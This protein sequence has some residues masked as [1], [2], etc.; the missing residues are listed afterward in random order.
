MIVLL[1]LTS[2]ESVVGEFVER[3]EQITRIR[4]PLNY[5]GMNPTML[6]YDPTYIS[7]LKYDYICDTEEVFFN[8]NAIVSMTNLCDVAVKLY[9][10]TVKIIYDDFL[11]I[12][13]SDFIETIEF[14]KR[15]NN[16]MREKINKQNDPNKAIIDSIPEN[17]HEL[18]NTK[19]KN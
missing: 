11:P 9:E 3:N 14:T 18:A 8:N 1:K 10:E 7:F 19:I 13:D 2:S 12:R 4:R 6:F 5:Y 16:E 17:W 15:Q